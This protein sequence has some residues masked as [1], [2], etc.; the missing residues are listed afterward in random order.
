MTKTPAQQAG[1][2]I[3]QQYRLVLDDARFSQENAGT[4]LT[5]TLDDGTEIP[6]FTKEGGVACYARLVDLELVAFQGV[7]FD[8][9]SRTIETTVITVDRKLTS[10]EQASISAIIQ[11]G[12]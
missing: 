11:K 2:V 12:N 9:Q 4:I 6:G 8:T 7:K 5:F 10:A 1:F 3:G